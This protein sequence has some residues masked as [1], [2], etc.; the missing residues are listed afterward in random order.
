MV[1]LFVPI[2]NHVILDNIFM[3]YVF[4]QYSYI[5]QSNN[6]LLTYDFSLKE[7][8]EKLDSIFVSR[9]CP[10]ISEAR[11]KT[12]IRDPQKVSGRIIYSYQIQPLSHNI[13]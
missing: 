12:K 7:I 4:K 8:T 10:E 5:G 13:M 1:T 6:T 9:A 3:L 11:G 2:I